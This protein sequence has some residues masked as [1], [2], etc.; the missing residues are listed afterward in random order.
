MGKIPE[1]CK[2]PMAVEIQ[3]KEQRVTKKQELE[4]IRYTTI[5]EQTQSGRSELCIMSSLFQL[6]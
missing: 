1:G 5:H 4:T 3:E 6:G 2:A